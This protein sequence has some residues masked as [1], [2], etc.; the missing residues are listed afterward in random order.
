MAAKITS[1]D[2][3]SILPSA[4]RPVQH[5]STVEQRFDYEKPGAAEEAL[6]SNSGGF[7]ELT[8]FLGLMGQAYGITGRAA[9]VYLHHMLAI[10][11]NRT[12]RG[13]EERSYTP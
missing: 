7:P 2:T 8:A 4:E 13:T 11:L 1:T 3:W 5:G 6:E 9:A 12:G 10:Y